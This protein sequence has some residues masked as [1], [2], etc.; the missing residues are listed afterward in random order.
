MIHL[1]SKQLSRIINIIVAASQINSIK[2]PHMMLRPNIHTIIY[3]RIGSGKSSILY[4]VA[5][6]I[7]Q[8]PI[9]GFTKAN[10]MGTVDRESKDL[11]PPVIWE[12]KRSLLLVDEYHLD[13]KDKGGRSM[14]NSLL[15]VLENPKYDRKISYSA[16]DFKEKDGDLFCRI[17]KGRIR[18]N[19]RFGLFLNTMMD[20]ISSDMFEIQALVSR[21]IIIPF[22]PTREQLS[23]RAKGEPYYVPK[24]IKVK[25]RD[26][27]FTKK[28]YNRIVDFVEA[29]EVK[30]EKFLR[31]V[32]DICRIYVVI[33]KFDEELFN[34]IVGLSE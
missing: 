21:C 1:D 6:N 31:L 14:L 29:K 10:L 33:R 22:Y 27:I 5:K 8:I 20:V 17:E 30:Q 7:E 3:G 12:A 26:Y 16:R 34:L 13:S 4:E 11:I 2:L 25:E 19:T 18:V 15:S 28:V 32:G 24:K 9:T 23:R